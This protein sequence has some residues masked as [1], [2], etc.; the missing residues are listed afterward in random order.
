MTTS[1]SSTIT[2]ARIRSLRA[3]GL[4]AREIAERLGIQLKTV[5]TAL[6][7]SGLAPRLDSRPKTPEEKAFEVRHHVAKTLR[8]GS[9]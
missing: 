5:R 7:R 1:H 3:K 2:T 4:S 6:V 9:L 8:R